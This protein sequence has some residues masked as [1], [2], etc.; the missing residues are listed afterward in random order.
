MSDPT[1]GFPAGAP[2]W[3]DA[4]VPDVA[5]G[6]RFYEQLFGWSFVTGSPEYGGYA[7]ATLDGRAVAALAPQMAGQ[8]VPPAWTLYFASPDAAATA[9]QVREHG[10][11]VLMEPMEI[12][13]F[14]RMVTAADPGGVLFGVWEAGSHH[15]FE[16]R[17]EPGTFCWAEV[18]TRDPAAADAFF[19]AVFPYE[20]R[21]MEDPDAS[22]DYKVYGF[23]GT[24]ALG[25]M[26]MPPAAPPD[27]PSHT[28]IYFAVPDC[29]GAVETVQ[30]L[31]GRLI[32]GPV[33]SPFGRFASVADPQGMTFSVIDLSAASGEPPP[34]SPA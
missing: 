5:A 16:R 1:A 6:R 11:R 9:E 19:P 29:D 33:D 8:E 31:G 32:E 25:R 30:Q 26:A 22:L 15:G 34:T 14:G 12:G 10:G 24:P 20:V 3:A 28:E 18:V 23:G 13:A 17:D 2:C 21:R 27:M 4:T 7:Q